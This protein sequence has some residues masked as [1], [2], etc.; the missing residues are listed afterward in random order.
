MVYNANQNINTSRLNALDR[1]GSKPPVTRQPQALAAPGI[2]IPQ[3]KHL[4][5]AA[6]FRRFLLQEDLGGSHI[7]LQESLTVVVAL[8]IQIGDG[9]RKGRKRCKRG[10]LVRETMTLE[11]EIKEMR[12]CQIGDSNAR[13]RGKRF[14]SARRVPGASEGVDLSLHGTATEGFPLP[15]TK[16]YT[17]LADPR[18]HLNMYRAAIMMA[19]ASDA[20]MCWGFFA[21]LDVQAQD[22][23]TSLPERSISTFTNF[24]G[25]FMSYLA[26]DTP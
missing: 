20:A 8:K 21:T 19:G 1:L 18:A 2:P 26:A 11:T 9:T 7:T 22:W 15:T 24:S 23:L 6:V 3:R 14:G 13:Y 16:I 10:S 12:Q 5:Q 25:K 4:L 17:G